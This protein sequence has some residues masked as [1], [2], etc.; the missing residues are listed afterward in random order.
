M[1][2]HNIEEVGDGRIIFQID[3]ASDT[4]YVIRCFAKHKDYDHWRDS[5]R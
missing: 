3:L 2:D 5:Y 1:V 4:I